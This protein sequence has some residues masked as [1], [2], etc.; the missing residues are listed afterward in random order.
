MV[1]STFSMSQPHPRILGSRR[2]VDPLNAGPGPPRTYVLPPDKPPSAGKFESFFLSDLLHFISFSGLGEWDGI[3]STTRSRGSCFLLLPIY[4]K[5]TAS[6]APPTDQ[7]QDAP[8]RSSFARILNLKYEHSSI[9]FSAF[10]VI[11]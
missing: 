11:C 10:S 5:G 9:L 2:S 6:R 7:G 4:F 1:F 3:I 8:S